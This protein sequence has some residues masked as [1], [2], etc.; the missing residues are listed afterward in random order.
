MHLG[1]N[2][3]S[4]SKP[5]LHGVMTK[6][7]N[8]LWLNQRTAADHAGMPIWQLTGLIVPFDIAPIGLDEIAVPLIER[9]DPG[10]V[11]E[12][13]PKARGLELVVVQNLHEALAV[14][15][16][17]QV[18]QFLLDRWSHPLNGMTEQMEEQEALH[19]EADVRID[20]DP[21]AVEDPSAR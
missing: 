18:A 8:R 7:G 1:R 21:Q 9:R 12:L 5:H 2:R 14:L 15:R 6:L 4:E 10:A 17:L 13:H 16:I 19:L 3:R 11:Q 20:D